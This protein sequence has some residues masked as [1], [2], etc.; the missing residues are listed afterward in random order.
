MDVTQVT[1]VEPENLHGGVP[2]PGAPPQVGRHVDPVEIN[3][4]VHPPRYHC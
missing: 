3:D 2:D 4:E 1:R